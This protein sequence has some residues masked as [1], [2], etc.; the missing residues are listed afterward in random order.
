M[1]VYD[2]NGK[3]LLHRTN[4]LDTELQITN[5]LSRGAYIDA[6]IPEDMTEAALFS[7]AAQ[8]VGPVGL[9]QEWEQTSDFLKTLFMHPE[10]TH[11]FSAEVNKVA[12]HIVMLHD[13]NANFS[14]YRIIRQESYLASNYGYA[15][16]VH[17][18][19]LCILLSRH[20]NWSAGRTMSLVSAALTMNM[21]IVKLQ[22]KMAGQ[23]GP[24]ERKQRTE[25]YK[26]PEKTVALLKAL[27]VTD[28][29]WLNAV[30]QHHEN[31]DG[32]G[33]PTKC[34]VVSD[35]ARVLRVADVFTAKVSARTFRAA[36][37]PQ[38]G[39]SRIFLED[40][41]GPM[42]M[43]LIKTLGIYPPGDFVRM[44]CGEL[45]IVVERTA[46][47]KAPIV[48]AITDKAGRAVSS[49]FRRNTLQSEFFIIGNVGNKSMLQRLLPERLYGFAIINHL[50]LPP[51]EI[52]VG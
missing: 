9:R 49:L 16:G 28:V 33:Y 17:S 19:V 52:S 39:I 30:L 43:A 20:F 4:V 21:S 2:A 13:I 51:L 14:V 44:A 26:H 27:G 11:D 38:E 5:L 41:G 22:G 12:A 15:H 37:S 47:A 32:T 6:S 42:S 48:A 50:N 40:N 8:G 45:G 18:A 10:R 35:I 7:H 25:I 1:N 23:D 29:D 31:A 24:V 34:K 3:L 46:H 36:L